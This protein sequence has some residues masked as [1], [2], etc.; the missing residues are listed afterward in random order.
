MARQQA[1]EGCEKRLF[2]IFERCAIFL[3]AAGPRK[4]RKTTF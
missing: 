4:L 1:R 3:A 2:K